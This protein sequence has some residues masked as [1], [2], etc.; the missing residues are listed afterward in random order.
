MY[1]IFYNRFTY[2]QHGG[3]AALMAFATPT[4]IGRTQASVWPLFHVPMYRCGFICHVSRI[5]SG[6]AVLPC[7]NRLANP[8]HENIEWRIGVVDY[9]P[10][11]R[12][13]FHISQVLRLWGSAC[14]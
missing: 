11:R 2:H 12:V 9:R 4:M 7:P 5:H 1:F 13:V 8:R 14:C 3:A 6:K 10:Y